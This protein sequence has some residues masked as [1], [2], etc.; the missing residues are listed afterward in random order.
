MNNDIILNDNNEPLIEDGDFVAAKSDAQNVMDILKATPGMV[1]QWPLCGVGVMKYLNGPITLKSL[2]DIKAA[3]RAWGYK[4]EID[5]SFQN[6]TI[7][8]ENE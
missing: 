1:K 5:Q 7:K 2:V 8:I 6:L 3:I 4:I